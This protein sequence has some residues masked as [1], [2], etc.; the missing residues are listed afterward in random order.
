MSVETI[1]QELVTVGATDDII[2]KVLDIVQLEKSASYDAG[3]GKAY[4]EVDATIKTLFGI[5]K[6]E[7]EFATNYLKRSV[8]LTKQGIKETAEKEY[9]EIKKEN[10]I[11]KTQLS[12]VPD[13]AKYE[14]LRRQHNEIIDSHNKEKNDLLKTFESEKKKLRLEANIN[15]LPL[16]A[17]DKEYL[18]YQKSKFIDDVLNRGF[19]IIERDGKTILKGG[20]SEGHKDYVLEDFAKEKLSHLIKVNSSGVRTDEP[21]PQNVM[22]SGA[23]TKQEA[24]TIMRKTLEEKGYNATQS[25]WAKVWNDELEKNK[26]ILQNLV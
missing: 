9:S 5:E 25:T 21:T 16:Q 26:S 11:L 17:E 8:D 22:L 15:T 7:K 1:K 23:K 2:T 14:D 13:A 6:N 10:D 19:E 24:L 12:Q 3:V 4:G 20:E 18:K